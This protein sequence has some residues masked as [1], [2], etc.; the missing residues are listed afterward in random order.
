[1]ENRRSILI[2]TNSEDDFTDSLQGKT[3]RVTSNRHGDGS[4]LFIDEFAGNGTTQVR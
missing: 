2:E 3:E 4:A 1:M